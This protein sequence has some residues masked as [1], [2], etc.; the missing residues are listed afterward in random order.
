MPKKESNSV[1]PKMNSRAEMIIQD[2]ESLADVRELLAGTTNEIH[3]VIEEAML[4]S[5]D[6]NGRRA[7]LEEQRKMLTEKMAELTTD[8]NSYVLLQEESIKSQRLQAVFSKGKTTW[9]TKKLEG[10]ALAHPELLEL[11]KTGKAS[12]SIREV[13]EKK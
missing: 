9:D 4:A 12:V 5:P 13:K 3:D 8:I 10:Y 7:E 11:K 1:P 6:L 2:L